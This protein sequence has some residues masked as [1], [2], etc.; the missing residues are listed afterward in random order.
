MNVMMEMELVSECEAYAFQHGLSI[1][2][3]NPREPIFT[4]GEETNGVYYLLDNSVKILKRDRKGKNL[5]LWFAEPEELIGFT[6]FIQGDRKYTTSARVGND[7][8]KAIFFSNIEFANLL[9]QHPH[10]KHTVLRI[11]CKR[12]TF[13]ENRTDNLLFHSMDERI[14][15]SLLLLATKAHAVQSINNSINVSFR[16]TKKEL[17]EMVGTSPEYL[18]KRLKELKRESLINYRADWLLIHDIKELKEVLSRLKR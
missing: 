6:S 11:L 18:G 14:L 15:E 5:F 2:H 3:F 4:Q 8:C 1:S 7:P 10:I 16:C 12:L 13:I 9:K 17:S